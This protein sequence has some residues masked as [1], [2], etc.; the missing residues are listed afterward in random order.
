VNDFLLTYTVFCAP[1]LLLTK[2]CARLNKGD[3]S[4]QESSNLIQLRAV[5]VLKLWI[6]RYEEDFEGNEDT[7]LK[8]QLSDFIQ[9]TSYNTNMGTGFKNQLQNLFKN[10]KNYQESLPYMKIP[11]SFIPDKKGE[12]TFLDIHPVELARQ[13]TLTAFDCCTAVKP[14]MLV[15][16]KKWRLSEEV[17]SAL[18]RFGMVR[19]W[20]GYIYLSQNQPKQRLLH[21]KKLIDIAETCLSLNNYNELFAILTGLRVVPIRVIRSLPSQQLQIFD[22]LLKLTTKEE[23]FEN[24]RELLGTSQSPCV[25]FLGMFL[26]DLATLDMQ[27]EDVTSDN[28]INFAKL[29]QKARII[30]EFDNFIKTP[31][32]LSPV[33]VIQEFL[34]SEF[35]KIKE[36]NTDDVVLNLLSKENYDHLEKAQDKKIAQHIESVNSQSSEKP[37]TSPKRTQAA[38]SPPDSTV[39]PTSPKRKHWR[40]VSSID[41]WKRTLASRLKA[42]SDQPK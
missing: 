36:L 23:D 17:R 37:M 13:L 38:S 14:R 26:Y 7:N 10:R 6:D 35:Q 42:L 15:E 8:Q 22:K 4:G 11:K 3:D 2:L 41:A 18:Q 32:N 28:L 25:P 29:R 1:Q 39:V 12:L 19:T 40:R 20:T 30:L 9:N 33:P 24:Y 27:S 16:Q 34:Y 21:L 31:Y 5:N